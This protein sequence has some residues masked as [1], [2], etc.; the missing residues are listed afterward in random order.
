MATINGRYL[1]VPLSLAFVVADGSLS[2][3]PV[4]TVGYG[5]IPTVSGL[6]V[7]GMPGGEDGRI[8]VLIN[9]GRTE[10]IDFDAESGSEATPAN[11]YAQAFSVDAGQS[12]AVI[13]DGDSSRWRTLK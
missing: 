9:L 10:G 3:L 11:R 5:L 4:T 8:V 6:N 12:R 7:Y 1:V 2:L 13:Y